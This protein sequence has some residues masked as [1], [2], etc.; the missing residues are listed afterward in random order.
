MTTPAEPAKIG[1]PTK[2]T[3]ERANRIISMIA[4]GSYAHVA[5]KANGIAESTFYDWMSRGQ[6]ADRD[7]DGNLLD[8]DRDSVFAEF[9]ERVK[10]AEATAEIRNLALIQTA[11]GNGTWQAA[12]W[13]LE[14]KY[15]DRW[16]RKD[17]IR[18]EVSGPGGGPIEVDTEAALLAFLDQRAGQLEPDE[19]EQVEDQAVLD[20]SSVTDIP[21]P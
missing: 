11:A 19:P 5:A 4:A 7:D 8:P 14:R 1:R 6:K 21:E 2:L 20:E 10:E 3:E 13:Y 15:A 16:G 18:S 17:H 9:S 12:A